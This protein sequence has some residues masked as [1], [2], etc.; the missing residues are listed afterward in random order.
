M[1]CMMRTNIR[2]ITEND[3]ALLLTM[4][5]EFY[6][7]DAVSTNGSLEIFEADINECI[8]GSVYLEGYVIERD[9][10]TVGYGMLARSYSTEF[11]KPCV[12][13]EDL[14]LKDDCRGCGLGTQFI[15][16][17]KALYPN[18]LLRLEVEAENDKA[19]SVYKRCGFEFLPYLEMKK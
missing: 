19:I 10:E 17:V 8:S 6:S 4:M 11:G 3:R 14:Y 7:S 15:E 18:A 1:E 13:I 12:W 16:Y 5:Q 2:K 9:G